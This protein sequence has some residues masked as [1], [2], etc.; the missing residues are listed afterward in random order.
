VD[1][2]WSTVLCLSGFWLVP[3]LSPPHQEVNP[4]RNSAEFLHFSQ[5][6]LSLSYLFTVNESSDLGLRPGR[7]NQHLRRSLAFLCSFHH[8]PMTLLASPAQ[9]GLH[10]AWG[11]IRAWCTPVVL[12]SPQVTK[13]L[14]WTKIKKA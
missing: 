9:Y 11:S 13:F 8:W 1:P 5:G 10:T 12:L 6:E 2:P 7:T 4:F 14:P 3:P